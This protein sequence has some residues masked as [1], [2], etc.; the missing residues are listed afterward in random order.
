MNIPGHIYFELISLLASITLFF[1]KGIPLYLRLFAPYLLITLIVEIGAWRM[2]KEGKDAS[3]LLFHFTVL[4]FVFYFYVFY[5]IIR[6]AAA[7]KVIFSLLFIY[8]ILSLINIY[9]IQVKAF[10]ST[11]YSLG[12]LLTVGICIYYF[13]ELFHLPSSV[14]LLREPAFWLCTGLMFYYI[15]SFPLFGLYSLLYST[16]NIIMKNISTILMVMNALL[17]TLFTVAFLCG[18]RVRKLHY[19]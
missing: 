3:L 9:F 15:C 11:T 8:P 6:T 1:R 12:C 19:K 18:T 13:Y 17:Y 4:E 7:R 14:N 16:S 2:D 5:N 10:P